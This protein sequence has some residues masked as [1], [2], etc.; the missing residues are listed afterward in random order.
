MRSG[1]EPEPP[2]LQGNVS[3]TGGPGKSHFK[4]VSRAINF[5]DYFLETLRDS[6]ASLDLSNAYMGQTLTSCVGVSV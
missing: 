1:I 5:K 4:I 2:A 3:T 6:P